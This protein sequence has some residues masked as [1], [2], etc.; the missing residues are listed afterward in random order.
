VAVSRVRYELMA[1]RCDQCLTTPQR[2]VDGERAA[3]LIRQCRDEDVKFIC[4]KSSQEGGNVACRGVHEALG[5]CR[6]YRMA[7]HF[8]IPIVEINPETLEIVP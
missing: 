6:A 2:I 7:K 3:E 4:H 1:E 8:G 5:G